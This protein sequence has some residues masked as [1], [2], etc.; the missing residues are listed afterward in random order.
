MNVHFVS[1]NVQGFKALVG[2]KAKEIIVPRF[3]YP[4]FDR[5]FERRLLLFQYSM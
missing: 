3:A 2:I 1:D 5:L 4:S